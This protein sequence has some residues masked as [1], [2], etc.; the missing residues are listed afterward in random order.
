MF[1]NNT[2]RPDADFWSFCYYTF[3]T[4][5]LLFLISLSTFFNRTKCLRGFGPLL[6]PFPPMRLC[7]VYCFA[8][9]AWYVYENG[10]DPCL[11]KTLSGRICLKTVSA[12][13]GATFAGSSCN[14]FNFPGL[15]QLGGKYRR[16]YFLE[17]FLLS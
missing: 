13:S 16:L 1:L 2:K 8:I 3:L 15:L 14:A 9:L 6:T 4:K 7:V 11:V 10:P 12:S 17:R 5:H